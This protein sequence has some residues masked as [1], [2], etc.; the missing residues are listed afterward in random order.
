MH[1]R[2]IDWRKR[3]AVLSMV[4][5]FVLRPLDLL[6]VDA[7]LDHLPQRTHFSQ[8]YDV[9]SQE[10]QNEIDLLLGR[11]PSDPEPQARVGELVVDAQRAENVR[12]LQAGRGT[13]RSRRDGNVLE[14]H[15]QGLAL[16]VGK[17]V[18]ETSG[19][20][21]LW[22]AIPD[23][24]RDVVLDPLPEFFREVTDPFLVVSPFPCR[25]LA[26]GTES[27]AQRVGEGPRPKA[28]F[29]PAPREDRLEA[30]AGAP[31]HVEGP[32]P[33]RSVD[34]VGGHGHQ[35]DLVLVDVD[36]HLSEHL[37]RVAVKD[38]LSAPAEFSDLPEGLE[39]PDLVVDGHDTDQYGVVADGL[40][41]LVHVDAAGRLLDREVGNVVSF[42]LEAPA[43]VE[44]TLVLGLGRDDVLAPFLVKV[45]GTL[46]AHVVAFGRTGG[47]DDF[48][49]IGAPLAAL[50]LRRRGV[51]VVGGGIPRDQG[52]HLRPRGFHGR[53][54]L[55]PK[56]VRLRVGVPVGTDHVG[57]HGVEDA[58]IDRGCRR[59]V[60]VGRPALP[61]LPPDR[62][63]GGVF[64]FVVL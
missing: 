2:S 14:R 55:P 37:C 25:E 18:V 64:R 29:L 38:D 53:L 1:H 60:Q 26:G 41:Q 33:L 10:F 9:L 47:E 12:G 52:G 13:G 32:D 22:V 31:P 48:L 7:L 46:D 23:D 58:G 27:H 19:V 44:D 61:E 49:R 34:L 5:V 42:H 62:K 57:C 45:G 8:S 50:L 63:A 40:P 21:V 17:A 43:A 36:R 3:R 20:V 4:V 24:L 11:E 15:E 35:I 39:G 28:A 54:G 6:E 30:D 51:V 59:H 56:G 16:D